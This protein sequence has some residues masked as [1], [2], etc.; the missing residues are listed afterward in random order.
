MANPLRSFTT[1][2]PIFVDTNILVYHQVAHPTFGPDSR[3]F[4]DRVERGDLQAVTTSV[5]VNEAAYVLQMQRVANILGTGHRPTI[6]ARLAGDAGI[7]ADAW[8][9]VEGF[10]DLLDALE[11]GGLT[12]IQVELPDYRGACVCGRQFQLVLSDATHVVVCQQL[13]VEHIASNDVDLDR[14]S[15]LTRWQPGI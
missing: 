9:A 7:A 8:A 2:D 15:F 3:D 5:C 10:L 13:G 6:H 4:L 14:A 12:V 1:S 11:R